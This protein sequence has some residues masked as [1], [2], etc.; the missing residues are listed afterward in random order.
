VPLQS[1]AGRDPVQDVGQAVT[2]TDGDRLLGEVWRLKQRSVQVHLA[3]GDAVP[4][5]RS[6][7]LFAALIDHLQRSVEVDKHEVGPVVAGHGGQLP[8]VV[9]SQ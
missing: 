8:P 1:K 3:L 5:P 2:R 9:S 7:V 6:R 4:R